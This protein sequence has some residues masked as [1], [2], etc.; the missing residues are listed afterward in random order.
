MPNFSTLPSGQQTHH[1]EC[2]P[3]STSSLP[4][5]VQGHFQELSLYARVSSICLSIC[6]RILQT[7]TPTH[8]QTE[9]PSGLWKA[10]VLCVFLGTP[11]PLF[12]IMVIRT[13]WIL[14]DTGKSMQFVQFGFGLCAQWRLYFTDVH[15][16]HHSIQFLFVGR[17]ALSHFPSSSSSHNSI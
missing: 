6:H 16:R 2:S 3:S 13:D 11:P 12:C 17:K 5:R 15:L 10:R 4:L 9:S 14:M 1:P 8:P 7:H